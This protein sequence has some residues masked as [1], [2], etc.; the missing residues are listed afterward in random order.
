MTAP[1]PDDTPQ[2]ALFPTDVVE[3]REVFVAL[4][5]LP[6][7]FPGRLPNPKMVASIQRFGILQPILLIEKPGGGYI[8]GAGRNRIVNAHAAGLTTIRAITFPAGYVTAESLTLVENEH[9]SPNPIGEALAIQDLIHQQASPAEIA[10]LM[11]ID[12]DAIHARLHLLNLIPALLEALKE[13]RLSATIAARLASLSSEVQEACARVLA[14]TG[15]LTA[16]DVKRVKSQQE[17]GGDSPAPSML[18]AEAPAP[19]PPAPT[20]PP[21]DPTAMGQDVLDF[22][23]RLLERWEGS[24][25]QL[26]YKR[27]RDLYLVLRALLGIEDDTDAT[28]PTSEETQTDEPI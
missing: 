8:V 1:V 5:D 15:K 14:E 28:P 13:N 11:G 10:E 19:P 18:P 27:D 26:F 7:A 3:G 6:S 20:P 17:A 24:R 16:G 12:P 9:R 21:L 4:A 23:G 22:L 2:L 25:G